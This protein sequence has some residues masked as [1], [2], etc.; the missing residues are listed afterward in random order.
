MRF[1]AGLLAL[2]SATILIGTVDRSLAAE[3]RV[4]LVI[5]NSAYKHVGKLPNPSSDARAIAD[6]LKRSGF[7]V[8]ESRQ[9]LNSND[10]RRAIRDF[11]DKTRDA[12]IA[13]V[14]YA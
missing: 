2:V 8:V 4:A 1:L 5:G 13:V 3:K 10:M 7:D 11:S 14:F 6:L 12:D 9:D